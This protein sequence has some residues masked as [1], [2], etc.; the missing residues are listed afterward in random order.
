M[1]IRNF[2]LDARIDGRETNL[3]AG[4]SEKEGGFTLTIYQREQGSVTTPLVIRGKAL[5][6]GRLRLTVRSLAPPNTKIKSNIVFE[7]NTTR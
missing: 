1:A 5:P 2:W 7:H 6:D 3:A 4:P